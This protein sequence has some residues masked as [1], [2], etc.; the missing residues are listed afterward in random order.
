MNL[1]GFLQSLALPTERNRLAGSS[2]Y[3]SVGL[4]L[5]GFNSTVRSFALRVGWADLLMSGGST[6]NPY[7]TRVIY[8]GVFAALVLATLLGQS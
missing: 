4:G 3:L 7:P 8:A 2:V 5:P 1:Y 6:E